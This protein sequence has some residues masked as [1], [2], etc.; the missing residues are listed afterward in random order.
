MKHFLIFLFAAIICCFMISCQK[1]I[2]A[3]QPIIVSDIPIL[4][5][6][7]KAYQSSKADTKIFRGNPDWEK[8]QMIGNQFYIPLTFKDFKESLQFRLSN[9]WVATIE[10]EKYNGEFIS[11]IEDK[12]KHAQTLT[13]AEIANAI[14]SRPLVPLAK[15]GYAVIPAHTNSGNKPVIDH[16]IKESQPSSVMQPQGGTDVGRFVSAQEECQQYGGTWV[17]I[18]WWY[19][20]YDQFGNV[21]F[22]VY[23]YSSF[24]C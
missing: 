21:I 6:L 7:E 22:E 23:V 3:D 19:Q 17:E 10:K 18:E 12:T 11:I 1:D 13:I 2:V 4:E 16:R 8:V 9:Y 5:K 24:E 20:E 14:H 15:S